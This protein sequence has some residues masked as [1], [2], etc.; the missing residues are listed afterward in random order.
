MKKN[1][2]T[3][4]FLLAI[5]FLA[6][7]DQFS[8]QAP[9]TVLE[10]YLNASLH[11]RYEES[12][13]YISDNDRAVKSLDEYIS[14]EKDGRG[15]FAEALAGSVSYK[16]LYTKKEK[17]RATITVEI[18]LPDM[19]VVMQEVMG[20][21]FAS[22]FGSENSE[23]MEKVIVGKFKNGEIPLVTQKRDFEMVREKGRWKVFMNWENQKK[24]A[25]LTEEAAKLK[26][27]K[28][29]RGAAEKYHQILVLDGKLI[30]ARKALEDAEREIGSYT[31]KQDY[32]NKVEL[33]D[34]KAAYYDSYFEGKIP[35]VEFKI[36]NK[37]DKTLLEIEVTA[38]FKNAEGTIIAEEKYYPVLV[39]VYSISGSNRPLKPN[40]IWQQ[41][42]G[43][44]YKADRVP[45]EW[46]EGAVSAKITNIEFEEA[47][48]TSEMNA[49]DLLPGNAPALR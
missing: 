49:P 34:L 45:S 39:S 46:K 1:F 43:K 6:A 32:I 7:C 2:H 21:A 41:E 8:I 47:D 35:G 26:K 9:S 10:R 25:Q 15:A 11:G 16:T 36:K 44:F 24:I 30:E 42:R 28:K 14:E 31:A 17:Y 38:Y 37:G 18:T 22:A 48:S 13:S 23:E 20:L 5:L 40:Y 19:G 4:L 29:Y 33:Y 12:Y 27:E 3:Y